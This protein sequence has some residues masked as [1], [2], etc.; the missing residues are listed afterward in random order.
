MMASRRNEHVVSY[1]VQR[2]G[3]VLFSA[4]NFAAACGGM[5]YFIIYYLL[6]EWEP[7]VSAFQKEGPLIHCIVLLL[8]F[9]V[10]CEG[11]HE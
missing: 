9:I 6:I 11:S 8:F 7:D 2:D 3:P 4:I 1:G 5:L 10:T